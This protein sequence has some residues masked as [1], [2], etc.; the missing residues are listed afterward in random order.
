MPAR[1]RLVLQVVLAGLCL[2]LPNAIVWHLGIGPVAGLLSLANLAAVVISVRLGW[3]QALWGSLGLAVLSSPAVLSQ[4]HPLPATVLLTLTAFTLGLTARWQQQPSFWLLIV[5]L[6][7]LV[8]DTPLPS[9]GVAQLGALAGLLLVSCSC[10]A[11]LQAVVMPPANPAANDPFSVTHSWGRCLGYGLLLGTT[12]LITT[13]IA[14]QQQW[15]LT[16]V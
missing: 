6:C 7:M 10:S 2:A 5:S 8:V 16:G 9:A 3:R 1:Q 12:T 14:L 13:P 4:G 15:H 11:L